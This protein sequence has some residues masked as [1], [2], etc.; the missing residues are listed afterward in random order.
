MVKNKE[1]EWTVK[2]TVYHG[3]RLKFTGHM[4]DGKREGRWTTWDESGNLIAEGT[5]KNGEM[6]GR[7]V[8]WDEEKNAT[9][10]YYKTESRL[11]GFRFNLLFFYLL[12]CLFKRVNNRLF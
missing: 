9:V 1:G 8:E 5:Y 2:Y 7:W 3:K 6:D 4:K 12:F 11:T 10:K